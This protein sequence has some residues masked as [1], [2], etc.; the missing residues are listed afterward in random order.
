MNSV[1]SFFARSKSRS[2]DNRPAMVEPLEDRRLLSVATAGGSA[3]SVGPISPQPPIIVSNTIIG[4]TI[5]PVAGVQFKGAVA[6]WRGPLPAASGD[7][8]ARASISWG[9]GSSSAGTFVTES[10]GLVKVVGTHTYAKPGT[11]T[12]TIGI[13]EAPKPIKGQPTP[14][15]IIEIGQATGKAIVSA[16]KNDG[17]VTIHP[18]VGKPF[19]GVVAKLNFIV[20]VK[21][22]IGVYTAS[23]DWGDGTTSPG[24]FAGPGT[25]TESDVIG[26]HSYAKVG[27]YTIHVIVAFG[28][29]P[30]SG[31]EFPTR[32]IAEIVSKAVVSDIVHPG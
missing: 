13:T 25:A 24:S 14:Q 31:A 3:I 22:G 19:H 30:G 8:V 28:P 29:A 9:D 18:I 7:L 23:I 17:G 32:I 26:T 20:P 5:Y 15:F 11:Y 1:R 2:V 12:T 27:T 21:Q 10:T 6:T 4:L 16:Q